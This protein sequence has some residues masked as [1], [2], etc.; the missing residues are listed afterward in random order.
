MLR[1][2]HKRGKWDSGQKVVVELKA[3]GLGSKP[4][5]GTEPRMK[6]GFQWNQVDKRWLDFD[7]RDP[8]NPQ[9]GS[10]VRSR[11]SGVGNLA[12]GG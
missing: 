7:S 5:A 4:T 10:R 9:S 1:S 2:F 3:V 8:L 6:V 12:G 11:A